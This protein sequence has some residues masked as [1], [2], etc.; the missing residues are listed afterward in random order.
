MRKR[1]L[2]GH[3]RN[4]RN[5]AFFVSATLTGGL[6]NITSSSAQ[7]I[8]SLKL[9]F[10]FFGPQSDGQD[11]WLPHLVNPSP[12]ASVTALVSSH[13]IVRLLLPCTDL[14]ISVQLPNRQSKSAIMRT[15]PN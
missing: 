5:L 11:P 10:L 7:L 3:R 14:A 9:A 8:F 13:C 1:R 12:W 6:R 4:A 2:L 15:G